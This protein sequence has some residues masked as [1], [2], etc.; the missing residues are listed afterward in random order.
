MTCGRKP[1]LK[2]TTD[3]VGHSGGD[4]VLENG[5]ISN[6]NEYMRFARRRC[7]VVLGF[8]SCV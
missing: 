8:V 1:F 4:G 7:N 2:H 5:P 3:G 6:F